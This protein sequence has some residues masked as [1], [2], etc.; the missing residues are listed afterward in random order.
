MHRALRIA[1]DCR[2]ANSQQGV[3]TA[4]L[5]LAKALSDSE[6]LDQEYTFIVREDMLDWLAPY[7][8]GPCRLQ[9]IPLPKTSPPSVVSRLKAAVGRITPLRH[10][11]HKLHGRND[12][13]PVSDGYVEAQQFDVVHFPTQTAYLTDVPS[14]YQPWDLQHLHYPEFFSKEIFS[15]REREYRAFCNQARYVCVQTEWTKRDIIEQYRLPESK[16]VVIPWGSVLEAYETPAEEATRAT[17]EKYS[18]P[19]RFFFYPA[20]TWPH[21]NHIVILRALHILKTDSGVT[22]HV[23][24]SGR[25]TSQR[26]MLDQIA[27]DLGI[28]EQVHYL[29]FLTPEELQIVFR[30]ATAMIFASKF[31]GFGLPILEAFDA[32]LPVLSSRASTLPEVAGDGALYFGPDSPE[33]LASLMSL[34]LNAPEVRRDLTRKG[35]LVLSQHSIDKTAAGFRE[36]Y[37]KTVEASSPKQHSTVSAEN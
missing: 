15:E 12:R 16:V 7:I 24:F 18:F 5:A 3:G 36:L 9:G 30:R 34:I 25:S 32:G 11:W 21:K 31:E 33:E 19:E 10:L 20:V 1:I 26:P 37:K 4:V 22:S 28:S 2:I 23:Y 29:G 17:I 13:I 8:Y 27:Q 14:I 35:A 6:I